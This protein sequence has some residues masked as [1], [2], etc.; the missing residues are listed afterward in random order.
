M[1]AKHK[2]AGSTPV[3]RSSRRGQEHL[4]PSCPFFAT[5]LSE[6]RGERFTNAA[7]HAIHPVFARAA[8]VF[9]V[10]V[11][12]LC[13]AAPAWPWGCEGHETIALVAQKHLTI[14]ARR[15][16][17]D[18]L[19]PL[20]IDPRL[21]RS[22]H[23]AGL[24][25]LAN[26]STWADDVRGDDSSR[27]YAT[28]RWHFIDIPRSAAPDGLKRFC[29]LPAGCVTTAIED[30]LTELRA[31][32]LDRRRAAEALMLIIHL[33]GDLHQPLHCATNND[34]GGNCVPVVYFG[35][36]PQLSPGHLESAVYEPNLHAVW[37]TN[38]I[39][40]LVAHRGAAWF[41]DFLEQRFQSRWPS[42]LQAPIDLERWAWESHQ[43]AEETVYGKL[44]VPIPVHPEQ[45]HAGCNRI[46]AGML[47]LHEQLGQR[48]QDAA[49]PAIEEQLAKAGIRLAMILNQLWP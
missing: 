6:N 13:V 45:R 8:S 39:R 38:I 47:R 18:L 7:L 29:P 19:E 21:E 37:D 36:E 41:A 26:V 46:S 16:V 22:C 14:H 23:P 2:V 42:W 1:L 15:A 20:P 30:Q 9:A 3:A 48:Y 34:S 4:A 35:I 11:A 49:A 10:A 40:R 5:L 17:K 25:P 44:P 43:V 32:R 33:V 28:G 31:H 12:V 27:L 24:D